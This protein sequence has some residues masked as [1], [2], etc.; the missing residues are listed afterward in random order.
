MG[1]SLLN[2]RNPMNTNLKKL[3][4]SHTTKTYEKDQLEYNQEQMNK[5]INSVKDKHN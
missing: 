3:R 4:K 5:I 2:K 1:A